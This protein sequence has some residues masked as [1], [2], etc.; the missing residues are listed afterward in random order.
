MSCKLSSL[1]HHVFPFFLRSFNRKW[2]RGHNG[3]SWLVANAFD[4]RRKNQKNPSSIFATLQVV[5]RRRAAFD[6]RIWYRC[7]I[8]LIGAFFRW[9]LEVLKVFGWRIYVGVVSKRRSDDAMVSFWTISLDFR[10]YFSWS[11]HISFPLLIASFNAELT[12]ECYRTLGCGDAIWGS[13]YVLLCCLLAL[14]MLL[15]SVSTSNVHTSCKVIIA[16]V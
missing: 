11:S 8:W 7:P 9:L 4:G 2:I 16:V 15:T 6:G 12:W 10:F 5:L 1:S 13:W 14:R 3:G